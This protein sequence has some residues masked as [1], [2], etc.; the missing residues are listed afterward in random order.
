MGINEILSIGT[1]ILVS[2]GGASAI[3]LGFSN[4]LG[5]IWAEKLM[6]NEK[7]K[8]EKEIQEI[9]NKFQEKLELIRKESGKEVYVHSLQFEKE[10]EIYKSLW[11]N[12]VELI[13][14][15][16]AL[17]PEVEC[18]YKDE[19]EGERKERKLHRL[20]EAYKKFY[21]DV[22]YSRPFYPNE[23]FLASEKIISISL[24]E[25]TGFQIFDPDKKPSYYD[26]A[27]KNIEELKKQEEIILERIKA[28]IGVLK[29]TN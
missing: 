14:A 2:L 21:T 27:I 11:G 4:W 22:F 25:K 16:S 29:I 18:I 6:L 3:I 12:L 10:F 19:P 9:N 28:R 17:R 8:Y 13:N 26:D 5:K 15:A 24:A 7:N 23:I 20:N 1:T